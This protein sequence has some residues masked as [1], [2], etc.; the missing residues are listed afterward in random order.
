MNQ[1]G[2][3]R[4]A[5]KIGVSAWTTPV[6]SNFCIVY[7]LFLYYNL[8]LVFIPVT[9]LS[10]PLIIIYQESMSSFLDMLE[11][12]AKQLDEILREGP[13]AIGK[14]Y[15]ENQRKAPQGSLTMKRKRAVP[16][17]FSHSSSF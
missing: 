5:S 3:L 8:H 4:F 10:F 1:V 12:K 17:S 7:A 6:F 9:Y 15:I 11:T 13:D 2:Y 14:R 16:K